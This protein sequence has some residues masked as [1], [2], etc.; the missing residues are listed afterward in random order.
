MRA[1][2]FTNCSR[3]RGFTRY[4]PQPERMAQESLPDAFAKIQRILHL[5]KGAVDA[6]D[7]DRRAM[8]IFIEVN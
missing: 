2:A 3:S 6:L 4:S 8:A 7:Y 5:W 1:I